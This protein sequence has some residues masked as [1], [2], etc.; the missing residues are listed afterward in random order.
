L[1]LH[2]GV[3]CRSGPVRHAGFDLRRSQQ[4]KSIIDV[5][6]MDMQIDNKQFSKMLLGIALS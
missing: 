3:R 4:M 5:D 6:Y 2:Q 1:L